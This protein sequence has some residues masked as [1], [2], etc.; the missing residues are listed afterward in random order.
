MMSPRRCRHGVEASTRGPKAPVERRRRRQRAPVAMDGR[1]IRG[2]ASAIALA[3]AAAL[4]GPGAG[5]AVAAPPAKVAARA[6]L[7]PTRVDVTNDMTPRY[8]E[9]E[10]AVNPRDPK[11]L[12]YMAM[13]EHYTY[14]CAAAGAPQC[15]LVFVARRPVTSM[16]P[17]SSR[18]RCTCP[19]TE[20]GHGRTW[21]FPATRGDMPTCCRTRTPW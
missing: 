13:Q 1:G 5:G 14:A 9:A 7:R 8:G 15:Q 6:I 20:A 16:S 10:V 11:N 21:H 17:G 4:L 19:S 18:T 3:S 12:V 2:W